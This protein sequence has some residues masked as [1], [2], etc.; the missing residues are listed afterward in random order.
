M[1]FG[2][3]SGIIAMLN[4]L[5]LITVLFF[6]KK[7]VFFLRGNA[8][9]FLRKNMF[10]YLGNNICNL[11]PNSLGKVCTERENDKTKC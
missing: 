9:L 11:F 2:L 7:K 4:F 10:K 8:C 1:K 6:R 3:D 5:N